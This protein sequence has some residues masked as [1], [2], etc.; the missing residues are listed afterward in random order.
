[1]KKILIFGVF[2]GLVAGAPALSG[3]RDGAVSTTSVRDTGTTQSRTTTNSGR[4]GADATRTNTQTR[5]QKTLATRA[6]SLSVAPRT[7]EPVTRQP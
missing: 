6:G 1:M 4:G 7:T 3:V 5:A 2:L